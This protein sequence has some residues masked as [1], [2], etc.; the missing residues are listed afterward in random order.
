LQSREDPEAITPLADQLKLAHDRAIALLKGE[1]A[2]DRTPVLPVGENGGP[3]VDLTPVKPK[4]PLIASAP[5]VDTEA[6]TTFIPPD[7]KPT[8]MRLTD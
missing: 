1:V 5:E 3:L 4:A 6:L 7:L 2:S 8:K